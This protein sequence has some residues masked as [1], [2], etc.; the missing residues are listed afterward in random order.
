MLLWSGQTVSAL[1]SR[2]SATAV[3]LLVLAMT[4]S[5][6]VAGI[7]GFLG[8]LPHLLVQL[9]A[10]VLVDRWDRWRTMLICDIGR[11]AAVASV[12]IAW[13]LGWLSITQVAVVA[14]VEA[15]L[16]VF[17]HLAEGAALPRIV[18]TAELPAALAQ[19][20]AKTRG[21]TLAGMPLGGLLFGLDRALPFVADAI[22][23]A[24]STVALLL[25]RRR[26]L[27]GPRPEAPASM[28]REA[29][30]GVRWL[31]GQPLLRAAV[32]LVAGSNLIFQA[33]TLTVI[34]LAAQRGASPAMIGLVLGCWGI[35]GL[36]GAFVAPWLQPVLPPKVVVIGVHWVWAAL[37]PLLLVPREPLLLGMVG[38]AA[39]FVGPLWNVVMGTYMLTLTPN[40]LLGRVRSVSSLVTWG[41]IPFG[42]LIGGLLLE[43][44]GP[45]ATV[46]SL[47]GLM[48]ALAIAAVASPSVRHAPPLHS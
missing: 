42:S 35:G 20:E 4:G 32:L 39:A 30:A 45:A 10:G 8:A 2:V 43:A 48:L 14:F 36:L 9:P 3:P 26:D 21:A 15:S 24:L 34:V 41:A 5:P 40:H 44:Y 7:I 37:L 28:W 6:A 25:M 27:A 16:Y 29:V 13:W 22:S 33:V 31:V 11:L 18:G 46:W 19:N 47:A 12:P 1:G 23:Y 38:A 17:F